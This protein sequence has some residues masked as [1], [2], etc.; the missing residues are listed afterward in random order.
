M[1][2]TADHGQ[3]PDEDDIDSYGIAPKEIAADIDAEFGEVVQSVWP[4][5]IFLDDDALR[6]E[7]VSV[8]EIARWLYNYTIED[9]ATPSSSDAGRFSPEERVLDM[10]IPAA[11]LPGIDCSAP[12]RGAAVRMRVP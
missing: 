3:Q 10:A 4:T 9:N 5:Q 1:V 2:V 7:G 11:L 12:A 8:A 6:R